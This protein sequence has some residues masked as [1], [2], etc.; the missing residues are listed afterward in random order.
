V[1][2]ANVENL[3]TADPDVTVT[4]LHPVI[5]VPLFL[6]STVPVAA[7]ELIV[8][9]SVSICPYMVEA[10]DTAIVVVVAV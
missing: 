9:V 8:A 5:D 4:E 10:F 6:K 3:H 2:T 1:P 7:D